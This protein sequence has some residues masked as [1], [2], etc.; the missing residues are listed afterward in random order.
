MKCSLGI[1]NFLEE[2]SSLSLS[3]V[4][5]YFFPFYCFPLFLCIV[6]LGRLPY[7]SMLFF[8]TLH[9]DEYIFP[10]LLSFTSLFSVIHKAPLD[11]HFVFLHFFLLG[12]VL[13]T[14]SWTILQTS[15]H[16]SS[17]TVYQIESLESM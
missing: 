6:H 9:S 7:V 1:S 5:L 11:N 3:I 17:V 8:G 12:M 16:S 10:F 2:I 14:A 13:I 4:F 15:I